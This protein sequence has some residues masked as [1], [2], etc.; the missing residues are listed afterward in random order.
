MPK[1]LRKSEGQPIRDEMKRQKLTLDQLSELTRA[2]DPEGRGVSPAAIGRLTGTGRTARD[3][4]EL[5][6]AWL[7]TEGLDA[8]MHRLFSMP[9]HSTATVE[10]SRADAE[11]E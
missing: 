6:T 9:P 2:V 8:R 3:R 5:H 10:R 4:C 11:E 1:V 7:I